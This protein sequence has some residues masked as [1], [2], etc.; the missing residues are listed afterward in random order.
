MQ[1][2]SEADVTADLTLIGIDAGIDA[3]EVRAKAKA[4]RKTHSPMLKSALKNTRFASQV[5]ILQRARLADAEEQDTRASEVDNRGKKRKASAD[6][7]ESDDES[8]QGRKD[9]R[10]MMRGRDEAM[11]VRVWLATRSDALTPE[12]QL[13]I[14]SL[15]IGAMCVEISPLSIHRGRADL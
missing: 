1:K 11:A 10:E 6:V 15:T 12:R 8:N 2:E 14:R 3:P 7:L 4:S 9:P 13:T 5:E